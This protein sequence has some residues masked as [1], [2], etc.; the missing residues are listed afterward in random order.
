MGRATWAGEKDTAPESLEFVRELRKLRNHFV[1]NNIDNNLGSN[2]LKLSTEA[3]EDDDVVN[4]K[5]LHDSLQNVINFTNY[6]DGKVDEVTTKLVQA[7]EKINDLA[8]D[9]NSSIEDTDRKF[10][11]ALRQANDGKQKVQEALTELSQVNENFSDRTSALSNQI[12]GL[13]RQF[14]QMPARSIFGVLQFSN[15]SLSEGQYNFFRP[16]NCSFIPSDITITHIKIFFHR[17]SDTKDYLI[18]FKLETG[19]VSQGQSW[20]TATDK[21]ELYSFGIRSVTCRE[22]SE[23]EYHTLD[24]EVIHPVNVAVSGDSKLNIKTSQFSALDN[25]CTTT[26]PAMSPSQ[27]AMYYCSIYLYYQ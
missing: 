13:A 27:A 4:K 22:Q 12:T 6:V 16:G 18:Q 1:L 17:A 3:K 24:S 11:E 10:V 9:V 5:C 23:F 8:N 14:N 20:I 15:D 26:L 7:D 19:V 25:S 21:V 2:K